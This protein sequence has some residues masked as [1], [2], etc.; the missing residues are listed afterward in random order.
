MV[1]NQMRMLMGKRTTMKRVAIFGAKKVK[2]GI[3][4]IRKIKR[5][6]R[7]VIQFILI[8]SILFSQLLIIML[9]MIL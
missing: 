1:R 8:Y 5:P 7:E 3:G 2:N 9:E 6:L 4:I